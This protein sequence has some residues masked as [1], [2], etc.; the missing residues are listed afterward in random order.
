MQNSRPEYM[1]DKYLVRP[2][3]AENIR[4]QWKD[5]STSWEKFSKLK[6]SHPM[7][8]AEFAVAL[9][10]NHEPAFNWW[11]EHVLKKRDKI[12]ASIRKWQTR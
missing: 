3:Q 4:F 10:I 12:I 6:E 9:G 11:V 5:G 7:Q 2:L 8:T 1:A